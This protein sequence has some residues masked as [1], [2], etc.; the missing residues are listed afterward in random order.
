[1]G[2]LFIIHDCMNSFLFQ[3]LRFLL[4][5]DVQTLLWL[6]GVRA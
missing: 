4:E 6:T 5:A 3:S 1:L 2:I